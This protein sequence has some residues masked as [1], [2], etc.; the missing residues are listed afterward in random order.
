M[1]KEDTLPHKRTGKAEADLKITIDCIEKIIN[2]KCDIT[3]QYALTGE[4]I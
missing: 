1:E 2:N 3:L 4:R